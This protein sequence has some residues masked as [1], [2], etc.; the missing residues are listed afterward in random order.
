MGQ[1]IFPTSESTHATSKPQKEHNEQNFQNTGSSGSLGEIKDACVENTMTEL[2]QSEV[3]SDK[4][5]KTDPASNS[6]QRNSVTSSSKP[7]LTRPG[8][9][10]LGFLS[11]IC[12]KNSLE[13]DEVT[14]THSKKRLKPHI[15]VSRRNLKKPNPLHASQ[16]KNQE[17]SDALPPPS[18]T[19][20][21][22]DNTGSSESSAPEV[23]S[24]Q[25]LLE[26]E[27]CKNGPKG[28][29]EEEVTTVS[30]FVFSDIFIEV[31]ETE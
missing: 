24:D 4:E 3:V 6:E 31:D 29:S 27:K 20:T 15:P 26:E 25:P 13:S 17:S 22:S 19:E 8:R 10:P 21:L 30:E 23:S 14:Q 9:R 2:P 12:P 11:L 18:V 28:A 16:K 7:P 1:G 5:E